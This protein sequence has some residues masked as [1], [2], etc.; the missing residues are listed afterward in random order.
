MFSVGKNSRDTESSNLPRSASQSV[1]FAFSSENSKIP[2]TSA[3]FVR[4]KGTGEA[5]IRP[6]A[7]DP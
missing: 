3:K 4:F 7:A 5:Q 2:R 6:Q 1:I